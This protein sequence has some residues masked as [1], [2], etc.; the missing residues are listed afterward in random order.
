MTR[1]VGDKVQIVGDDLF[2][3]KPSRLQ[4]GIEKTIANSVLIKVN[5]VGTLSET[6]DTVEVASRAGYTSMISHRSGETEDT[7][8]S[9]LAVALNSGQIKTGSIS[10]SERTAK[11]NRLLAIENDLAG[12]A[13]FQGFD[14]LSSQ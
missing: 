2:V 7:F 1:R 4:K 3:T 14:S 8:I 5:Q 6:F 9:D 10:R 11:Y 12:S 13:R